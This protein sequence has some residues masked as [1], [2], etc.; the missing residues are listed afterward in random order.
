MTSTEFQ[1]LAF[2]WMACVAVSWIKVMLDNY[3]LMKLYRQEVNPPF[4]VLFGEFPREDY[5]ADHDKDFYNSW[6]QMKRTLG[7]TFSRHQK[8]PNL[9]KAAKKV[10]QGMVITLVI[11][12]GGFALLGISVWLSYH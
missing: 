8:H 2:F 7:I 10:R 6:A 3:K 12:L 4:P 1:L 9:A 11:A 5:P